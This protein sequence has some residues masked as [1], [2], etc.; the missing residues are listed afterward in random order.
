MRI[1]TRHLDVIVK[2][3]DKLG[4]G[5]TRVRLGWHT[6]LTDN[7]IRTGLELGEKGDPKKIWR[8]GGGSS[9]RYWSHQP[10]EEDIAEMRR[11]EENKRLN[12]FKSA[13][14]KQSDLF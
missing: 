5:T 14:I 2:A 9:I 11:R 13:V 6:K 7:A 3:L 12:Y 1:N 10:T 4:C 8:S